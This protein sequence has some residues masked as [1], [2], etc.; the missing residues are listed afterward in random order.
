MGTLGFVCERDLIAAVGA[1]EAT[2]RKLGYE[3]EM[4]KGIKELINSL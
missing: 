3:F 2:L 1:L 4:G